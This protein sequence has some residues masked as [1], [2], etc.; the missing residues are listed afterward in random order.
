M[1]NTVALLFV[2]LSSVVKHSD[3]VSCY[4]CQYI[5]LLSEEA[6]CDEP[7]NASDAPTCNG[8]AC[9]F[10]FQN[11]TSS[12]QSKPDVA[13]STEFINCT[14]CQIIV[15]VKSKSV[16]EICELRK[17]CLGICMFFHSFIRETY[18]SPLQDTT[19]TELEITS[20]ILLLRGAPNTVK[21]KRR[22]T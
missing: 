18:T 14:S 1:T 5:D 8:T 19:I 3:A 10:I 6:T 9:E 2:L 22:R 16:S 13:H 7:F 4:N 11:F 21:G 15:Q 12:K 20:A 17:T